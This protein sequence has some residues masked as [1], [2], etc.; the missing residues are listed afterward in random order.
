[1]EKKTTMFFVCL[2]VKIFE[3][4]ADCLLVARG[5]TKIINLPLRLFGGI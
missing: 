3:Q 2:D 4:L 1:M 5:N